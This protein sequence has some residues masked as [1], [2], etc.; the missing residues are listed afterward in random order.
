M[1]ALCHQQ[2]QTAQIIEDIMLILACGVL[3]LV[4][5]GLYQMVRTGFWKQ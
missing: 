2:N 3:V 5:I 4:C 1:I